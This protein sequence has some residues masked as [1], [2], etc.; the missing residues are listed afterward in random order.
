VNPFDFYGPQFLVFYIAFAIF[1]F[2]VTSIARRFVD[3]AAVG[4]AIDP[5]QVVSDPYLIAYLRGGASEA[6]RVA[7]ISLVDRDLLTV[8]GSKLKAHDHVKGG[9]AQ[10]LLEQKIL[11]KYKTSGEASGI[12]ADADVRNACDSY[13]MKLK[14]LGLLP[15]ASITS[16]RKSLYA[17]MAAVLAI[18]A[19]IKVM[20][21][22][23][24]GRSVGFLIVLAIVAILWLRKFALPRQTSRG[25][26]MIQD[27]QR[28][29]AGLKSRIRTGPRLGATTELVML[30]SVFGMNA[31]PATTQAWTRQLFPQASSSSSSSSSGCGSSSSCGSSCGGGCGGGCGGCGG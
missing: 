20:I 12:F 6:A 3:R 9:H 21:G 13:D 30:V 5:A 1:I 7:A 22:L 4:S 18:V 11:L 29:F 10:Q 26:A 17:V 19:G 8:T 28:L 27:V 2:I 23:S 16:A 31:A 24:R 14:E 15:N 25:K